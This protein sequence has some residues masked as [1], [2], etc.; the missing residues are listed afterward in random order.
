MEVPPLKQMAEILTLKLNS[1]I[2]YSM[3]GNYYALVSTFKV[4]RYR[5]ALMYAG[6][7]SEDVFRILWLVAKKE[8]LPQVYNLRR[9]YDKLMSESDIDSS[10]RCL[11]QIAYNII[12][13]IRSRR[14]AVHVNPLNPA[15][16][17]MFLVVVAANWILCE[18]I[19]VI[20]E[21]LTKETFYTLMFHLFSV[22]LPL[23][24]DIGQRV[25]VLEKLG[26]KN[27][28]MLILSRYPQGLNTSKIVNLL[29]NYYKRST[30]YSAIKQLVK[31][32]MIIRTPEGKYRLTSKG[33]RFIL[34]LLMKEYFM[35]KG[36]G[37]EK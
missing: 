31:D 6:R 23:V 8:T 37:Y 5:E 11:A 34:D 4:G 10:L 28:L 36:G 20:G 13:V 15:I 22:T 19:R 9:I 26:C 32:R 35:Y 21:G 1:D 7:F 16:M 14:D 29:E 27:E 24:E 17:D 2:V 3:L 12:Y 33:V 18:I 25:V 30:I